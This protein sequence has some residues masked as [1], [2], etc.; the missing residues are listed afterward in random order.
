MRFFALGC[1][2]KVWYKLSGTTSGGTDARTSGD[3]F[4][5]PLNDDCHADVHADLVAVAGCGRAGQSFS[6]SHPDSGTDADICAE[7]HRSGVSDGRI[8]TVD[9]A[10]DCRLY[11]GSD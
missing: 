10:Y 8:G 1:P 11:G 4:S 9:A 3:G 7:D 5:A 2:V 6:G